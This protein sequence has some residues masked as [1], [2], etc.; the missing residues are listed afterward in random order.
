MIDK[1]RLSIFLMLIVLCLQGNL[2]DVMA[3]PPV[4]YSYTEV[5]VGSPTYFLV[6]TIITNITSISAWNWNFGDGSFSNVPN[7]Q[8][9]FTGSGIH[10]VSLTV[11]DTSG[12]IGSRTHFVTIESLPNANFSYNTPNCHNDPVQFN[13]LSFT[14]NGYITRWIWNFGD[15][16]PNDT[17]YFPYG[18]PN[19]TH[20]FPTW[21]TF[22]VNLQV[23][24]DD[25]CSN[26]VTLPVMVT[27]SPIANFYYQGVCEDQTVQ[28]TDASFA[29]GAGNIV[30]WYWDFGDPFSGWNN[31]SDLEDPPHLFAMSG[32]YTITLTVTNYTSCTDTIQ[33]HIVINPH[34]P[35]DFTY[36]VACLNELIYF[37]PNADSTNIGAVKSWL[38]DF[39]DNITSTARNTAHV[40]HAPGPYTVTLTITDTLG[41]INIKTHLVTINLLPVAHFDA[42]LNNCAGATVHFVNYSTTTVGY[43][44]KWFWNF[45]DGDTLTV[46]QPGNPDVTHIYANPGTYLA[47]LFIMASDGCSDTEEQLITI[48]PNPV[49]YFIFSLPCDGQAVSFTDYSQLGGGGSIVQWQWNFGDPLSGT[50]NQSILQHPNHLFTATGTY[51]VQLVVS[52]GNG[53]TSTLTLPVTVKP[54]PPVDFTTAHNCQGNDVEFDPNTIVMNP[55]TIGTWWWQF[56]DGGTSP[57]QSPTHNYI[58]AGTYQ[59]TLT[60]TD[61]AGCP[62]HIT[63]AVTIIPRPS[64]NFYYSHPACSGSAVQFTNISSAPVGY[65]VKWVWD[66][67]DSYSQTVNFLGNPNVTHTYTGYATY[68]VTLTVTT[69]DSCQQSVT[70]PVVVAPKPLANFTF[71]TTCANSPVQFNDLSQSGS[72][73]LAGWEW[74]FGDPPSGANNAST[75]P[76]PEHTFVSAGTY[77]V[78]LIVTNTGGCQDTIT[79]PVTVH[80]L[81]V[82]N[83]SSSPG[84]VDDSTHFICSTFVNSDAVTTY[85]WDFGDNFTSTETDPYHIYASSGTFVVTLTVTDTADCEN[86]IA[87]TVAITPPPVSFFEVATPYCSG[88]PVLFNNLSTT[89]GGSITSWFWDFGDGNDTLINAPQNPDINHIYLLAG[90]YIVKLKINTSM[91]CENESQ[92]TITVNASPHAEFEFENTCEGSAVNFNDMS[93]INSGTT[94]TN[95]YWDFGDPGSGIDNTSALQNPLHIYGTAGTYTVILQ[96]W[97]ASSCPD[98]V[99]H[100]VTVQ[101]KPPVEFTWMNTCLGT[102]TEFTVNTTVTNTSAVSSYDWDFGDGIHASIQDPTH[103]YTN[104][105]SFPVS[106]TIVDTA[107]CVNLVLHPIVINPQPIAKFGVS[108]ACLGQSTVFDD[109]SYTSNGEP[110]IAWHWDFGDMAA[111]NDTSNAQDTTWV[112]SALGVYNASLRVTSGSGCQDT[113]TMPVQVYGNPDAG[114]RFTAAPCHGGAVYFQDSSYSQLSTVIG[115]N[116]EFTPN[117]YS[118]LQNPVYVF[119][120]SDSCYNVRLIATDTRGCV[121]TAYKDVCVPADFD[122]NFAPTPTCYRDSMYFAPHLLAPLGDSLV[123]FHWN[124]GETSSG[125]YNTSTLKNPAHYYSQP[126]TYTV[127]LQ[128]SDTNN[129]IKT[130]YAYVIVQPLPLPNFSYTGGGCDSTIYFNET[131]SGNGSSI[132]QWIWSYGDGTTDTIKAPST[133]AD[134]SHF[135]TSAGLYNVSLTVTNAHGCTEVLSDTNV[136]VKPCIMAMFEEAD[137]LTCQNY[138]LSFADSSY[139]GLPITGWYWDFGDGATTQY[140]SYT[141][142][143]THLYTQ[144]GTYLI[145]MRITTQVSGRFVSD[146]STITVLVHPTPIGDFVFD[147]NCYL[148][149]SGFTNMT[150]GNGTLISSWQWMFGDTASMPNDT[151]GLRDPAHLFTAPGDYAVSLVAT[152]TIGCRDTVQKTRTVYPLPDANYGNDLSCAGD[153]TEFTDLSVLAVAPID[154]WDWTF[155]GTTGLLGLSTEQN[156]G[157]VFDFPG[158]YFVKLIV[159]DTNGCA[160]TVANTVTTWNIPTSI[161][162]IA[163]NFNDIQGQL[164]FTNSSAGANNYFWTFGNGESSYSENPVVFYQNGG[165]YDIMLVT[166]ND[167]GCTDTL[168]MQYEFMIKGLYIPNAFSPDNPKTEVQLLKPVGIN[169]EEYRF[170]VYDR[171][172]SLLWW[173]DK[174]DLYGRPEEGWDGTYNG[175][176]MQEGVYFWK[177]MAV[178]RDGTIWEGANIGNQGNLPEYKKGTATMIK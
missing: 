21:G 28:F 54:R 164:Q 59:V 140:D 119:P 149:P 118:T 56:G 40:Y 151:S 172:G 166:G 141:N 156:P 74:D 107:G 49:P 17:I 73:G 112:Y 3:Q 139:C 130:V 101:P 75:L 95:W 65:I 79:I 43:I 45:G 113:A 154:K 136:L 133:A 16:T 66:F 37:N 159:A 13:D 138:T 146:S 115:W 34:P 103:K 123:F 175:V 26:E 96:I 62:N 61:T 88:L 158:D 58:N 81:P 99:T 63:K 102:S 25:S 110:I 71:L 76:N 134:T 152:N 35:V 72:G 114:F 117:N 143:V 104:T 169:L 10:T 148:Q 142:P 20:I 108:S 98:T 173:S 150:S 78:Q 77:Q 147:K 135:Y 124:F 176:L 105:G 30:A 1:F 36:T 100:T 8:H 91:G 97:N 5:C 127:S 116:W 85:L 109:Q 157:F 6:D 132:T 41:C 178:F 162:S 128:A 131:S 171:W 174:L 51:Q 42:G 167:K 60:V 89:S 27:P 48:H 144:P 125:I 122:F 52:S 23:M 153:R 161:F 32:T 90:T 168:T 70:L 22:N 68:D 120:Y 170:E 160:D 7:P 39:G 163:D 2:M 84:C 44:K 155:S 121:D 69:N 14:L 9:T 177:A 86:H 46:F 129:C 145:K 82:V 64:A 24:T 18:D 50:G 67:G 12:A 94:L 126:G 55:A 33:K 38:W 47:S 92:R 53:C 165:I 80:A 4:D 57:Q 11:T 83:F 111:T 137:T 29:N 87:H 15:G 106:L 19:V 31:H 93:T